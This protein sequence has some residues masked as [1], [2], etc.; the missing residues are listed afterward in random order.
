MPASAIPTPNRFP[1]PTPWSWAS[2]NPC[3]RSPAPARPSNRGIRCYTPVVPQQWG[4][5]PTRPRERACD[6]LAVADGEEPVPSASRTSGAPS[7]PND[8][9]PRAISLALTVVI[10][11]SALQ[12]GD[13]R[14][15]LGVAGGL[16]DLAVDHPHDVNATDRVV[17]AGT[18]DVA[19]ADERPLVAGMDVLDLEVAGRVG[20]EGLPRAERRVIAFVAGAVGR[21]LDTLHDAVGGN[22]VLEE[23]GVPLP[24]R[25]VEA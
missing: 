3:S 8:S 21:R 12:G 23:G 16:D 7:S 20:D 15:G 10:G 18:P 2:S 6:R 19:P 22:D 1:G 17:G 9:T 25:P 14:R 13:N 5:W 24:E 4:W 11:R